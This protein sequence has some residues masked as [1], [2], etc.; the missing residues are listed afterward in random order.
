MFLHII[1]IRFN[2]FIGDDSMN[3]RT[4]KMI[5]STTIIIVGLLLLIIHNERITFLFAGMIIA[6]GAGCLYIESEDWE[7]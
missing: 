5:M 2:D 1:K 3:T 6:L 4:V 7:E